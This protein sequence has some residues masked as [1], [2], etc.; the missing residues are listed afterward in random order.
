VDGVS[1]ADFTIEDMDSPG[2][3]GVFVN[4]YQT[5]IFHKLVVY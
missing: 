4:G 1:I 3:A 2:K 5:V